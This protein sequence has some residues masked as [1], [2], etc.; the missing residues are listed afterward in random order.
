MPHIDT[1][2]KRAKL[3]MRWRDERNLSVGEKVRLL[4]R[5]R[6]LT[7]IEALAIPMSLTLAQEIVAVEAGFPNWA[8]LKAATGDVPKTPAPDRGPPRFTGLVLMLPVADV[9]AAA[10]HYVEKLGFTLDFLHGDPV[11]YGAVSRDEICFHLRLVRPGSGEVAG[12]GRGLLAS[13][14]VTNVQGLFEEVR[15]RGAEILRPLEKQAW[16]G[17]DFHVRDPDGNV[18][19]FVTYDW[20]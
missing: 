11:F 7:D 9:P 10:A 15:G 13:I 6:T 2:R 4:D 16:G 5:Y 14:E 3:L 18:I 8:A 12:P 17:S 19:S 20:S 1:Y